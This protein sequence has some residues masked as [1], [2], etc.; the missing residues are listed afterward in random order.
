MTL[1]LPLVAVLDAVIV[2]VDDP[3]LVTLVGLSVAVSPVV[4]LAERLTVPVNPP[5]A[6]TVQTLVPEPPWETVTV[7]GLHVRLKSWTFTVTVVLCDRDPLVPVTVTVYVPPVPAQLSVLFPDPVTLVGLRVHVSPVDGEIVAVRLT[8]PVPPLRPITLIV[9]VPATPGV[10][11]TVVG[12]ANIWK[13]TTWTVIVAVVCD[14]VPLVPVT[15]T[16]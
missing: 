5:I 2:R 6:V 12:L 3:E 4:P 1:T 14:S 16:V 13:S 11:L 10:V 9:E 15:V 8:V 7:L